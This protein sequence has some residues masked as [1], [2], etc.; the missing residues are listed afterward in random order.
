MRPKPKREGPLSVPFDFDEAMRRA[1]KVKPPPEGWAE[2]ERRAKQ[3][4]M[5]EKR[6]K[7]PDPS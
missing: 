4:R 3:E 7:K 2:H 1:V 5:R 6:Q